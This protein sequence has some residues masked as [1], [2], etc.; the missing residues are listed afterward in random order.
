MQKVVG[1]R[2]QE[3]GKVYYFSPEGFED[4]EVGE[5]VVVETSRGLELARVV[6]AP[7]QV[8]NAEITEPLKPITR[9]AVAEDLERAE[10]LKARAKQDLE[11]IRRMV[12][13]RNLP[14]KVVSASYNLDG[15][16]LAIFFTAEGRVD[17][18]D[19]IRDLSHT[20]GVQ[21]QLRQV[22]PRD[23]AKAVD[24]YGICGRR[25]CCS[26]W[27]I[28]F[29][30]ISI[31]MAKEQNKP[32]NPSKIS[33]Q[34]GRLLCCLAYENEMYKQLKAELPK[35]GTM[36]STPSGNARVLAANV[37]KQTVTLQMESLDVVEMPVSAL[38]IDRGV[39]RIISAPPPPPPPTRAPPTGPPPRSRRPRPPRRARWRRPRPNR[40]PRRRP[41]P[42]VRSRHPRLAH[43]RYLPVRRN[44]LLRP[45]PGPRAPSPLQS[46]APARSAA[47]ATAVVSAG[48]AS[49][50]VRRRAE[51]TSTAWPPPAPLPARRNGVF[52]DRGGQRCRC[53][54]LWHGRG[55]RSRR[56][57]RPW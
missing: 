16:R 27:L 26:S 39:V 22:G 38:A 30:A 41:R 23:Q 51:P 10:L 1:V 40:H 12:Q 49:A 35:P 14:M 11:V 45:R 53:N 43:K 44:Q 19:L 36:V 9:M 8:V 32:L 18:R 20:L 2:F 34:C 3:A 25:L 56:T 13:E 52:R 4:L 48:V 21:V 31:K 29:P 55:T 50:A 24:G 15:S 46:R 57:R 37:L 17:F 42:V 33:G 47:V 54:G 28:S 6:I 5:Y 7:S